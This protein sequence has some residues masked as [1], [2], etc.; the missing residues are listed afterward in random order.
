MTSAPIELPHP[1]L[2]PV[3]EVRLPHRPTLKTRQA[4]RAA[5][6]VPRKTVRSRSRLAE[7]TRRA[8]APAA[9][10]AREAQASAGSPSFAPAPGTALKVPPLKM[11]GVFGPR[12]ITPSFGAPSTK[13]TLQGKQS[14]RR[15]LSARSEEDTGTARKLSHRL[16]NCEFHQMN[17]STDC[18]YHK[19][20]SSDSD[21]CATQSE[22]ESEVR[23]ST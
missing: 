14:P 4:M 21:S 19:L 16:Q 7:R 1:F 12:G 10:K 11:S 15:L 23:P 2:S 9:R 5:P 18:E 6:A 3:A 13:M 22:E 8:T 20:A 17:D